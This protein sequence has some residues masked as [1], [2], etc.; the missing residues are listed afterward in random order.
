M[1]GVHVRGYQCPLTDKRPSRP[2]RRSFLLVTVSSAAI[3]MLARAGAA[4]P[5][6]SV[7][8]PSSLADVI[9]TVNGSQH[10][11]SVDTR[12]SLLDLL[13]EHL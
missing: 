4:D 7:A 1:G 5:E 8:R 12:T 9:L 13:P 3:P 10:W 11:L 2:N 6:A